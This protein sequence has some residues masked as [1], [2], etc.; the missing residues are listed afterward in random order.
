MLHYKSEDWYVG[1]V[2]PYYYDNKLYLFPYKK[3]EFIW[4]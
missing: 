1:D 3:S 4:R 2:H